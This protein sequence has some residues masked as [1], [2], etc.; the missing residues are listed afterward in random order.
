MSE[1]VRRRSSKRLVFGDIGDQ[2]FY[3]ERMYEHFS[4]GDNKK[5]YKKSNAYEITSLHTP[6][7]TRK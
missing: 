7:P 6:R 2:V 3:F 4:E 5:G 1:R